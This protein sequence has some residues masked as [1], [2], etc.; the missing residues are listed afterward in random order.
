MNS[1]K[2]SLASDLVATLKYALSKKEGA[3]LL[4]NFKPGHAGIYFAE[5]SSLLLL[6]SYLAKEDIE[7]DQ[8]GDPIDLDEDGTHDSTLVY[9]TLISPKKGKIEKSF[10]YKDAVGIS[11]YIED[12]RLN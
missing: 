4:P 6:D 11:D 2:P 12:L 7:V 1:R 9:V 8:D 5:T 3:L 10:S